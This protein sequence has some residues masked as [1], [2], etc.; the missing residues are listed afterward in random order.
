MLDLVLNVMEI[1]EAI[2]RIRWRDPL[3]EKPSHNG[4]YYAILK[5]GVHRIVKFKKEGGWGGFQWSGD[6]GFSTDA[7]DD[8][9]IKCWTEL[10]TTN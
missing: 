2:V 8:H 7:F 9:D 6:S 10:L 1:I 5:N 4:E 3:K